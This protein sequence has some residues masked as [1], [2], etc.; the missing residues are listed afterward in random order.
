VFF[1]GGFAFPKDGFFCV[2]IAFF[3]HNGVGN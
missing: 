2:A 1:F 3:T